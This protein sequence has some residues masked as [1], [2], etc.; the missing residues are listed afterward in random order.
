M[1]LLTWIRHFTILIGYCLIPLGCG[2]VYFVSPE[3]GWNRVVGA[4]LMMF[5]AI[6]TINW[7]HAMQKEWVSEMKTKIGVN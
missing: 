5:S 4:Y 1:E 3:P 7:V 6:E 2:F